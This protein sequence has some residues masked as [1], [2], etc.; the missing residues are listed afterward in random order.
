MITA[1]V[2]KK[3]GVGKTTTAVNLAAALALR[4]RRVLLVDLDSQASAS[5][6]FG[7]PRHR[8]APSSA[9]VLLRGMDP[10]EAIRPTRVEGLHLLT[11]SVDLVQAEVELGS[12]QNST[13][14]LSQALED[15]RSSFDHVLVDCPPSVSLLPTNALVASDAFLVPVVPHFLAATGVDSLL[16]YVE[17]L[18]WRPD[19]S[20]RLLGVLLTQVDYRNRTV[21]ETVARLREELGDRVFATEVRINV[22]LAEAPGYGQTIFEFDAT[23][24]GAGAHRL[25][26]GEYEDRYSQLLGYRL[27]E[28]SLET[29]GEGIEAEEAQAD[30]AGQD[31]E[32]NGEPRTE[33]QESSPEEATPGA[34]SPT[35]TVAALSAL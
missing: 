15:V 12:F 30:Q 3:G 2:S 10:A 26:A 16:H 8:L 19:V 29:L 31:A 18:A 27:P 17:R 20:T 22:R 5:L 9:D 1:L 25:L 28:P 33:A 24:T 34:A 7:V 13:V 14:R 21:R 4:G 23:A 11:A 6:S 35:E 32:G